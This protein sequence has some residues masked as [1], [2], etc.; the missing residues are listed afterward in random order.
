MYLPEFNYK[1]LDI[2]NSIETES[3]IV[4]KHKN[5]FIRLKQA[6]EN[7]LMLII[8][9]VLAASMLYH[10]LEWQKNIGLSLI[11]FF[12][13]I[14]FSY[15]LFHVRKKMKMLKRIHGLSPEINR[16]II[17]EIISEANWLVLKDDDLHFV[18]CP[19]PLDYGEWLTQVVIINELNDLLINS[20]SFGKRGLVSPFNWLEDRRV[21]RI[22]KRKFYEKLNEITKDNKTTQKK[23]THNM[24]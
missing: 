18:C 23:T 11:F 4:H 16:Q 1:Y 3:V 20:L 8:L 13:S 6:L 15:W 22:I 5:F 17:K 2:K 24:V 19:R 10:A 9:P 14:I 21:E 12:L 7:I